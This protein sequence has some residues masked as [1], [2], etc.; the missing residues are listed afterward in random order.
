MI[1]WPERLT[2]IGAEELRRAVFEAEGDFDRIDFQ[3]ARERVLARL[4]AEEHAAMV[5]AEDEAMD[6]TEF[7]RCTP[8]AVEMLRGLGC[9]N[10]PE[11]DIVNGTADCEVTHC[12]EICPAL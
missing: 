4:T 9:W 10:P 11:P 7:D 6:A 8:E 5:V 12:A 3:S 1:E 2:I